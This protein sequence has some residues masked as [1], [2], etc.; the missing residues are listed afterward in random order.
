MK[1]CYQ[2]YNKRFSDDKWD[3]FDCDSETRETC[4]DCGLFGSYVREIKLEKG[5]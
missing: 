2:C 3:T 4:E 1:L 5:E